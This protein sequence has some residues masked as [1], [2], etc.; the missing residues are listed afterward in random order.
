LITD[1][2]VNTTFVNSLVLGSATSGKSYKKE[3]SLKNKL[4]FIRIIFPES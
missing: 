2:K 3:P 4:I 1:I